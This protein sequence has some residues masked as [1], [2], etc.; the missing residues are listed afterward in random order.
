MCVEAGGGCS[1]K[2]G[3][4]VEYVRY[5]TG[6]S[7]SVGPFGHTALLD[8]VRQSLRG[9]AELILLERVETPEAVQNSSPS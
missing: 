3:I 9:S 2:Q 7:K 1:L 8:S 6:R 4:S 5:L